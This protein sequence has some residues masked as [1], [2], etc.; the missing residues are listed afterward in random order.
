MGPARKGAFGLRLVESLTGQLGGRR[1]TPEVP[2]GTLTL[3]SFPI[4]SEGRA[5]TRVL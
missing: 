4:Q 5:I 3:L 1:S 2:K